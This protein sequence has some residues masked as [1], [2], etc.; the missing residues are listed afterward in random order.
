METIKLDPEKVKFLFA[1]ETNQAEV[2]IGL[3]K[4][5][6]PGLW[7]K[8]AKMKGFPK[9]NETTNKRFFDMFMAFDRKHH[10][11]V[12]QGGLWMNNGF[13]QVDVGDS[14]EDWEVEPCEVEWL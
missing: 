3:Y 11:D 6:Y 1:N 4:M 2:I 10:P 9:I 12:M 8:I 5:V 14:L 7:D 13:S